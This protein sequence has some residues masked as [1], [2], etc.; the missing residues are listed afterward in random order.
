M[1]ATHFLRC[2]W[3]IRPPI[4]FRG[5]KKGSNHAAHI[6]SCRYFQALS[7]RLGANRGVP[8]RSWKGPS[9]LARMVL[10]PHGRSL[11]HCVGRRRFQ[12]DLSNVKYV[13][14]ISAL[15]PWRLT[16]GVY[17]FDPDLRAALL[18]TGTEDVPSDMF[19]RL[20]EWSV[21]LELDGYR[22]GNVVLDG[23]FAHLEFDTNARK[24]ELRLLLLPREGDAIAIRCT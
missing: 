6:V 13:A 24:T 10:L 4:R 5:A 1:W 2:R 15:A 17:R 22:I 9:R 14:A 21:Y 16:Q 23:F 3:I 18:D 19:Y 11:R 20:P 8:Q 12:C 7:G